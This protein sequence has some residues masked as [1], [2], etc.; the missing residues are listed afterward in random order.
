MRGGK[1]QSSSYDFHSPN[2]LNQLMTST[3]ATCFYM[4]PLL[5]RIN[6]ETYD[7]TKAMLDKT[8]ITWLGELLDARIARSIENENAKI[9]ED[10]DSP[11]MPRSPNKYDMAN[12]LD[13]LELLDARIARIIWEKFYT[14]SRKNL[15]WRKS[16]LILSFL[17][18]IYVLLI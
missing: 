9:D 1:E 11:I 3:V 12:V 4:S 7:D 5:D 6:S 8:T 16:N 13:V 18:L 14:N 10:Y 17:L 15:W 2:V